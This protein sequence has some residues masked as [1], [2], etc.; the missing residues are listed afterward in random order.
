MTPQEMEERDVVE[1][2]DDAGN[3][4][5]LEVMDYFFYNGEEFAALCDAKENPADDDPDD[6][7][8]YIMKI[9]T[10]TDE[11]GEEM[12]EFVP[13]DEELMEKLIRVVRTRFAEE[14]S[15]DDGEDQE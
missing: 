11:N 7:P 1:F 2:T 8:V 5:L 15:E 9:N 14:E 12:E 6:D 3:T 13:P 4:L 10:F